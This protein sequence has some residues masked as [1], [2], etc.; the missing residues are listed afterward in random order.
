MNYPYILANAKE[1][2]KFLKDLNPSPAKISI[3]GYWGNSNEF[4]QLPA[5]Y[6]KL[7]MCGVLIEKGI[8]TST[9]EL[10]TDIPFD[11]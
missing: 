7:C 6:E 1:F 8:V 2:V 10:Y 3:Y 5:G 9:T 4:T 11:L